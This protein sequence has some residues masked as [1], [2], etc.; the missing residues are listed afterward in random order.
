M[1][2]PPRGIEIKG[3]DLALALAGPVVKIKG[4]EGGG[5]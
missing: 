2:D 5:K 3:N 1:D 4:E